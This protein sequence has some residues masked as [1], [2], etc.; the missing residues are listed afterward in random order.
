MAYF[1]NMSKS[2]SLTWQKIFPCYGLLSEYVEKY[3]LLWPTKWVCRKV[4]PWIDRKYFLGMAYFLNLSKSIP[5]YGLLSESVKKC[6][7]D[8]SCSWCNIA[9]NLYR[10]SID[11]LRKV[12]DN[13]KN[14]FFASA[15]VLFWEFV[16]DDEGKFFD[17]CIFRP[18][19]MY[20]NKITNAI[21]AC[22]MP[23]C[24]IMSFCYVFCLWNAFLPDYVI[25]VVF[26]LLV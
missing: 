5:C 3:S 9:F 7:L 12:S 20:K 10:K 24:Q 19:N 6:F 17:I 21:S 16:T 18:W 13:F 8:W 15:F 11:S 4:Y 2:I 14:Y 22:V 25:F 26:F 23:I 1:V